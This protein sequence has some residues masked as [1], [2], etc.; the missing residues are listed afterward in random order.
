MRS[1]QGGVSFAAPVIGFPGNG[2]WQPAG[3]QPTSAP[4]GNTPSGANTGYPTVSGRVTA[5]AVDTT[6]ATGSTAYLGGAAGGVWKTTNAGVNWIPLTDSQPSLSVGSIAIDPNNHNTIFVGTGEEN[7]NQD[8]YDGVGILKSTDGGS[9][10]TQYGASALFATTLSPQENGA[11]IGAVAVQPGNSNIVLAAVSFF[12]NGT[13]GGIFRSTD[14][15]VTWAQVASGP[16]GAAGTDVVFEPTVVA[17]TTAIVYAAMGEA[18]GDTANGIYKSTD[19]GAT[20]TKLAGGLPTGIGRIKLGYAPSTSGASA[21]IYA[22]IAE[23]ESNASLLHGFYVTTNGGTSWT[24]VPNTPDFCEEFAGPPAF[25]Q[26]YYDLAIAVHPTNPNFVVVGGAAY[27]DNSTTLFKA[28]NATTGSPTWSTDTTTPAN[29]FTVGS[30][31][32]RPH[33]DTHALAFAA[34]GAT[35]RLYTG[36]DGGVWRTDDSTPANPLWV[37]LNGSLSLTQF[38]PGTQP[39]ISDEDYGFGGTQDNDIQVFD[40]SQGS[41]QWTMAPACGDGGYT[42]V[43]STTPTTIYAGCNQDAQFKVMKSVFYG[44]STPTPPSPTAPSFQPAES[45]ISTAGDRMQF[46]PPLVIDPNSSSTLYFASC[47]VWQTTDSA[48]TWSPISGD[49]SATNTP[50]S[51]CPQNGGDSITTIEVSP[52]TSSNI[53]A[54]TS[55]GKVWL[56]TSGGLSFGWTEIDNSLLP[57]RHITAVRS[58]R[59]DSTGAIAYVALSGFGSCTGCDGKGHV[60][61]SSNANMGPLATWTDI[62]GNLPDVPVNDIYVEHLTSPSALDALYIATDVGVFACENAEAATP[63]QNWVIVGDPLPNSPVVSLSMR[64]QGRILRASTHGRGMWFIQ[65]TDAPAPPL[66]TLGS[67]TPAAVFAG[68]P[69]TTVNV[70]GVNF[71]PN[72]KATISGFIPTGL[73]TTFVSTTQLTVS[74]PAA[75]LVSGGVSD[76]Q[77]TDPLGVD[78]TPLPFTV[79]NPIPNITSFQSI[80]PSPA[81]VD[82]PVTISVNGTGFVPSTELLFNNISVSGGTISNGGNTIAFTVPETD[83][84]AAV[85]SPGV[86]VTL[87]NPLPGGGQA[88]EF[89]HVVIVANTTPEITFNPTIASFSGTDAGTTNPTTANIQITNSGGATLNLTV[90]SASKSGTN[91]GDFNLV[92]PTSGSPTCGIISG[93]AATVAVNAS[94]WF[95]VTFSPPLGAPAGSRTAILTVSDGDVDGEPTLPLSGTVNGPIPEFFTSLNNFCT[96]TGCFPTPVDFGSVPVGM[97]SPVVNGTLFNF[98]SGTPPLS[99]TGMSLINATNPGDF[100]I[101]APT[102]G[103]TQCSSTFPFSLTGINVPPFTT[104]SC[105]EG[106][107]FTPSTAS[108]ETVT[109]EITFSN[110][111]TAKIDVPLSGTGVIP[112]ITSISPEGVP[113]GGPALTLTVTGTNYVLGSTVNLNGSPRLTTFG[114]PTQLMASLSNGDL[115]TA[116]SFAITVTNPGGATSEP[117]TLIVAEAP[118]GP[119][120]DFNFA[121][122]ATTPS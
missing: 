86:V 62:S 50:G 103:T 2:L 3:P 24:Q 28:T 82:E 70:T 16:V 65:L 39:S 89:T 66:P 37:D 19:S 98:G 43:D 21:T 33:V 52:K 75:L 34:N 84:P 108:T 93:G 25:G 14:G 81:V 104:S 5:I 57:N 74:V 90:A 111:A 41:L 61:K 97:A 7:F 107:T 122:L 6:D 51:N 59:S 96:G 105:A 42:A 56:N 119:N 27:T 20:W 36:D 29:D 40:G 95:G 115:A 60:F 45:A 114:G 113:T 1:A 38:Y 15:G 118:T 121:T 80:V 55:N 110:S 32:V 91:P 112:T 35:P 4:F 26:C 53:L 22:A 12:D 71:S 47:R 48:T 23:T 120:D 83:L 106:L 64:R 85:A 87:L 63:C 116:G 69:T 109:L 49:L 9:T 54:G 76:I 92:A 8:A 30:T 94:C 11:R 72:T 46:I 77:L 67:L 58:K 18:A 73:T 100:A 31:S 117:K 102:N 78:T 13:R 88:P 68:S 10:W 17:G 101:V 44:M 99:V 79:M